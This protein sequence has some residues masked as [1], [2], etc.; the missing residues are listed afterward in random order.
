VPHDY[1]EG[2]IDQSFENF[3]DKA[4]MLLR[5]DYRS[6]VMPIQKHTAFI[7]TMTEEKKEEIIK[8]R[9]MLNMT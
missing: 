8:K 9:K 5:K 3:N 4:K 7:T 1:I 2:S 6:L